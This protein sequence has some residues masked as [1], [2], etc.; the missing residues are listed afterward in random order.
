MN[1]KTVQFIVFFIL[2]FTLG[3][4]VSRYSVKEPHCGKCGVGDDA[5]HRS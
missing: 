5:V 1:K 2:G 4:V 3:K